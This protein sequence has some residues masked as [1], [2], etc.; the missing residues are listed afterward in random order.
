MKLEIGKSYII[1]TEYTTYINYK[2]WDFVN[3]KL[4]IKSID[5]EYELSR[6]DIISIEKVPFI[7]SLITI[8]FRTVKRFL[9]KSNQIY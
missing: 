4:K 1:K 2:A 7:K 9:I 3:K 6:N 8:P 5:G